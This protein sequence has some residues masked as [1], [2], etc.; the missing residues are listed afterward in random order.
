MF[1]GHFILETEKFFQFWIVLRGKTSHQYN[2]E[3]QNGIL[4][5]FPL[6]SAAKEDKTG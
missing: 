4:L 6:D 1:G 3:E 5:I 2:A